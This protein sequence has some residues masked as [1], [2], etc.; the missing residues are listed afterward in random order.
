MGFSGAGSTLPNAYKY[1]AFLEEFI[2]DN[3]I[4]TIVDAGCG[5]WTFSKEIVWGDVQYL[6]VDVVKG[7]IAAN[8][9]KYET[10]KIRFECLDI[11]SSELPAADLLICKDVLMHLSNSDIIHFMKS[12]K[13]FKHCLF[14]NNL[15]KGNENRDI[16]RGGFRPLDLKKPPFNFNG[17]NIF[18]YST[19]HSEKQVFY[20]GNHEN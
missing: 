10:D 3:H 11:L 8:I 7:V 4:R 14:T 1:I 12:I 19:D 16:H 13:K 17:I 2:K 18:K 9:E 20:M 6:G 5:D 15:G